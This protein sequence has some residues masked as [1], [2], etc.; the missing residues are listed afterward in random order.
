VRLWLKYRV[1]V[2]IRGGR[3]QPSPTEITFTQLSRLAALPGAPVLIDVR[4]DGEFKSD[5]GLIP[6]APTP[7][8]APGKAGAGDMPAKLSSRVPKRQ[9]TE[10][11]PRLRHEGLEAQTL[12]GGWEAWREF[13]QP[14]VRASKVPQRDE[15]GQTVWVS[16]ARPKVVR[17]ACPWLIRRFIHPTA[18][19]LFVPRPRLRASLS[20]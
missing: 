2:L 19:F 13:P 14:L 11:S 16:R 7:V 5:P 10:P 20:T 4:T 6:A 9:D 8:I 15:Q 17:V 1:R 12:E 18:V 3:R